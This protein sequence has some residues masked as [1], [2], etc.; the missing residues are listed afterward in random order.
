LAVSISEINKAGG[1]EV[2][3]PLNETAPLKFDIARPLR[4]R[5]ATL[6]LT[7]NPEGW[8]EMVLQEK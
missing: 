4:S 3:H 8:F 7:G 2:V 6:T 5:A 1:A